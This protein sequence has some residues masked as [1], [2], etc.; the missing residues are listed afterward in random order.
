MRALELRALFTIGLLV[1][2]IIFFDYFFKHR[3]AEAIKDGDVNA[4][5]LMM[6]WLLAEI[7]LFCMMFTDKLP[8]NCFKPD[9]PILH[10]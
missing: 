6:A 8:C 4:T 10:E 7:A 1:Y 5:S 2:V 3:D 9:A